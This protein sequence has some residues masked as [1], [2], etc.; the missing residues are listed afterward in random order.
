[1]IKS[2]SITCIFMFINCM[3]LLS[4]EYT[5]TLK[6]SVIINWGGDP[7]CNCPEPEYSICNDFYTNK[8]IYFELDDLLER[9]YNLK[10]SYNDRDGHGGKDIYELKKNYKNKIFRIVV[11]YER[12]QEDI[13][14]ENCREEISYN[15]HLKSIYSIN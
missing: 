2:L 4:V 13:D 11:K 5:V 7:V 1:M 15:N 8:E 3:N 6:K 9:Y 14:D 12:C 10:K